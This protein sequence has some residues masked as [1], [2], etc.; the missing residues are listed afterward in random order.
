[1]R[2]DSFHWRCGSSLGGN[3]PNDQLVHVPEAFSA[4]NPKYN[5][6]K[7]KNS[8]LCSL[9]KYVVPWV[10]NLLEKKKDLVLWQLVQYLF[11]PADVRLHTDV[12]WCLNSFCLWLQSRRTSLSPWSPWRWHQGTPCAWSVRWRAHLRSRCPGSRPT[13]KSGP[14]PPVS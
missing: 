4:V 11:R 8:S 14:A 10:C 12:F 5:L 1:M 6:C 3:L 9:S 13:A 7:A 2:F